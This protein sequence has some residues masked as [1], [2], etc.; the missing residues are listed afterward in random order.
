MTT[1]DEVDGNDRGA[2][3]PAWSNRTQLRPLVS[4]PTP[5]RDQAKSNRDAAL[6]E[7][8]PDLSEVSPTGLSE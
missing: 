5:M 2:F 7:K 4:P 1:R 3:N 6:N 8:T